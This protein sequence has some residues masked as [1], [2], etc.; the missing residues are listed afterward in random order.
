MPLGRVQLARVTGSPHVVERSAAFIRR[1]PAGAVA[2][3]ATLRGEAWFRDED[4]T[5]ELRPGQLLICDADR[6]FARGFARGLEELAIKV[7]AVTPP[8]RSALVKGPVVTAFA[9]G[10]DPYARALARLADRATRADHPVAADEGAVIDLVAVLTACRGPGHGADRAVALRAAAYG[11]IEDH[12]A[13]PGLGAAQIAAAIGVSERHLSRVLAAGGTT[14]PRLVRSRRLELAYAMLACA[15]P[16][17][18][19]HL[20]WPRWRPGAGSP[21][22]PTSRTRSASGSACARARSG[23]R[24]TPGPRPRA[25]RRASHFRHIQAREL[26]EPPDVGHN[27]SMPDFDD[28]L[29]ETELPAG[30]HRNRRADRRVRAGRVG[31]AALCLSTLG[32]PN[33]MITKYRWTANTPA[34][35]HHQP[36]GHGDL[37]RPRHR[38]A[39]AGRRDRRT[40]WS[41]TPCSARRSPAR[42]SAASAPGART[43]P[44]RPTT[45]SPRRA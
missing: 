31:A 33:I 6:P 16:A 1:D 39:G 36:A 35:A 13:D 45:S 18:A 8:L 29:A 43:R 10:R 24:A 17:L 27:R 38:G 23:A 2:V 30:P 14:V 40:S 4:G 25:D 15:R 44:G 21:R 5:R 7:P 37:P 12:L 11:F 42:R 19:W 9:P 34:R 28:G 3:Y 20:R 41:A 26:Q 32:I 22:R